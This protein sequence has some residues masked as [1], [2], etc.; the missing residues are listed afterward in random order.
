MVCQ[1]KS[2]LIHIIAPLAMFLQSHNVLAEEPPKALHCPEKIECSKDKSISSCKAFGEHL[3]Y[4][5]KIYSE[6]TV[7][8]GIYF[9]TR[10]DSSYQNPTTVYSYPNI[11]SY[12]NVDYPLSPILGISPPGFGSYDYKSHF[13]EAKQNDI[14][15]WW[16]YGYQAQ[17]NNGGSI[18]NPQDCPLEEVPLVKIKSDYQ[19]NIT[20]ISAYANGFLLDDNYWYPDFNNQFP[21]KAINMYKT[22]DACSDTGLCT[23]EL[24]ATINQAIV[25]I[26]SIVIDM[27]NKMKIVHVHAIT[28]FK[29]SHNEKENSIEIKAILN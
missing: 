12:G 13:W 23:I 9:L 1:I 11:C 14:T 2:E 22:W 25:D 5:G 6:G 17:C 7:K 24:M 8:K 18:I 4:W 28:G 26:G 29:I 15:K 16:I 3:E 19:S 21:W 10:I 27:D 20:K